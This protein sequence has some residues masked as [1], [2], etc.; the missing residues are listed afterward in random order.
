MHES[1]YSDLYLA[2]TEEH[3]VCAALA[4][5]LRDMPASELASFV[6]GLNATEWH[7]VKF[8]RSLAFACLDAITEILQEYPD[9]GRE[10][11]QAITMMD[12]TSVV[13]AYAALQLR[14]TFKLP[15]APMQGH[16]ELLP[17]LG[18]TATS[19]IAMRDWPTLHFSK[20][21]ER[22]FMPYPAN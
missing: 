16:Y 7:E 17:K 19:L 6:T 3:E 8:C 10:I 12:Q 1:L 21:G 22:D 13:G 11:V 20:P 2:G 5:N 14:D 4:A 15:L 18:A 9:R